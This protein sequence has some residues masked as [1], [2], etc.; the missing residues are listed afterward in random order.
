MDIDQN[1]VDDEGTG[2]AEAV[3]MLRA[4]CDNGFNG[5]IDQAALALGR[6]TGDLREMLD[7]T[8]EIDDDLVSKLRGIAQERSIGLG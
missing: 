4:F 8:T 3:E 2:Q 7:G 6:T 5:D 1:T